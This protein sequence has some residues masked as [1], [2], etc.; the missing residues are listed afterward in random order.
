MLWDIYE[1]HLEEAAFL[2]SQWELALVALDYVLADVTPLQG[3]LH[4]HVDGLVLGSEPVAKR[5]LLPALASDEPELINSK[6]C[7]RMRCSDQTCSG[8]SA[9]AAASLVPTPASSSR[10]R[11]PYVAE[12]KD[13]EPQRPVPLGQENLDADLSSKATDALP[14]PH[15][16][17]IST[18]W[19][20]TRPQMEP[21]RRYLEGRLFDSQVLLDALT[22]GSMRRRHVLA[23]ELALRSRG[24]HQVPTR[25]FL[26]RQI[27]LLRTA[28][29]ASPST[30]R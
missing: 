30:L 29:A 4:A 10:A 19:Q 6:R 11:T 24:A 5:I 21:Q 26:E 27:G 17:A 16:D 9:S 18:W 22:H 2:W 7:S 14:L 25:A 28:R 23:L 12:R 8:R 15:A 1:Q 3:R 13:S 20:Q